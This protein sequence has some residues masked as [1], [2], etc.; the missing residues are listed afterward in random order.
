MK[1]LTITKWWIWGEVVMVPGFVLITASALALVA[2]LQTLGPLNWTR[3]TPDVYSQQMADLIWLGVAFAVVGMAFQ[4][5]AWI[6][7]VMNTRRLEDGRWFKAMFLAGMAGIL[8]APLFGLGGL[9]SGS[10]MIAYLV[11]GPDGIGDRQTVEIGRPSLVTRDAIR[12]WASW[13]VAAMVA[14]GFFSLLISYLTATGRPLQGH[15][16]P[17]LVLLTLG[18]TAIGA[19]VTVMTAAWWGAIFNTHL[20]ADRSWFKVLLWSGIIGVATSPLFGV[21]ALIGFGV[22]IAYVLAG[23]DG[24]ASRQPPVSRPAAPPSSVVAAS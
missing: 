14:G 6:G 3:L 11:G 15:V 20:L 24:L 12:G 2:H 18:F 8:T 5:V 9:I 23:P 21:G 4:L 10:A 22:L 13:A 19:G 1:K 7:A 16:W 17:A